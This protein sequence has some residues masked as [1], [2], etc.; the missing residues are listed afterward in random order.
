MP[1]IDNIREKIENGLFEFSKHAVDQSIIRR[2][3]VQDV[4]RII[5]NGTIIED[6]PKDKYEVIVVNDRSKDSTG[7]I[8]EK[9]A[10][11]NNNVRLINVEELTEEYKNSGKKHALKQGIENSNGEIIILTDA[12]CLPAPGW[13]KGIVQYFTKDTGVV[14]GH[15]PI[16]GK[17]LINRLLQLDNLSI[18]AV[19]A[20]GIG[21]GQPILSVGR[22]FA[23][24]RKVYDEIGGFDRDYFTSHGEVDFC[25][26]AKNKGYKILYD[27]NV[28]VRHRVDR[29]GTQTLERLYYIYRNKLFVIRK[30]APLPQRWIALGLY[31][32]FW[33]PKGI[34][35]S[36]ARNGKTN[37]SQIKTIFTAM[38]DGWLSKGGK[39]V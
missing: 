36:I 23:Y 4:R 16:K 9:I 21:G 35:D 27:P 14:V 38:K 26:K 15:S 13:I 8:T 5:A 32:I 33:L 12:D 7:A 1:L 29:G 17:G 30:N 34:I 3:S 31:S 19:G 18:I 20:G 22:N 10:S 11:D 25:L 24:R 28:K 39:R 2:I 6:Y 37:S